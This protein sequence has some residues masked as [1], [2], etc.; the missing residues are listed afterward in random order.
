MT[1]KSGL[2]VTRVKVIGNGTIRKFGYGFLL[3]FHSNYGS[4]SIN[5]SIFICDKTQDNE[6]GLQ[7]LVLLNLKR[8]TND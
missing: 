6:A 7:H 5:Q 2:G 4:V 8:N 1:L 3:A